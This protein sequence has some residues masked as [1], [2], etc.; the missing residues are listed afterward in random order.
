MKATLG[1]ELLGIYLT[2]IS[3]LLIYEM[4][5]LQ[6]WTEEVNKIDSEITNNPQ[7]FQGKT[8]REKRRE[9]K[10]L[11]QSL[12]RKC[13]TLTDC[14]IL[15]FIVFLSILGIGISIIVIKEVNGWFTVVP[16]VV[17][18]LTIIFLSVGFM[19]GGQRKLSNNKKKLE[20]WKS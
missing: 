14:S 11:I 10:E 6:V 16:I 7:R 20:N 5:R 1:I 9:T 8:N 15:V 19:I 4:F 17:F 2:I 12:Q 3:I 13:P 18:V